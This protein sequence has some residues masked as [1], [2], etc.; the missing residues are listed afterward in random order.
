M[1]RALFLRTQLGPG[2]S[3]ISFGPFAFA[4]PFWARLAQV[5]EL[6]DDG[7][8]GGKLPRGRHK[9]PRAEVS[10]NQRK[11][12]LTAA[13]EVLAEHGY[14]AL[15]VDQVIEGAGVSRATFYE[16][17]ADK[18]ECVLAAHEVALERL[19]EAILATCEPPEHDWPERVAAGVGA[20]LG[21][22]AASPGEALLVIETYPAASDPVL[23]NH[24]LTTHQR[25]AE[26]LR[27]AG[28]GAPDATSQPDTTERAVIGA[29]MSVVAARLLNDEAGRLPGLQSELVQLILTPY[30][31]LAEARRV[32]LAAPPT[33]ELEE[34]RAS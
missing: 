34:C 18:H 12:L 23:A 27:P 19:C 26:M 33:G 7:R 10:A 31:G 11:R 5:A 9:I 8:N 4:V 6:S 21:F 29:T 24:G 3:P 1:R 13:I 14:T 15:T 25:L 20:A 17:F 28:E 30:L 32:A 2:G 16:Q 22:A